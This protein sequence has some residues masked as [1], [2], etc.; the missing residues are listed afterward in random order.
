MSGEARFPAAVQ[1]MKSALRFLRSSAARYRIDPAR[2]ALWGQ[3]AGP[4]IALDAG[5]STGVAMFNEPAGSAPTAD[6]RVSAI[7]SMYRPTDFSGH[8]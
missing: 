5:I 6:D 3:S 1:D 7:V 4:N 8:G 2:V